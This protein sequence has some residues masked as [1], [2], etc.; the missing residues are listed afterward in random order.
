MQFAMLKSDTCF[1]NILSV[2][3]GLHVLINF[4]QFLSYDQNLSALELYLWELFQGLGFITP[5]MI[6]IPA[7]YKGMLSM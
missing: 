3:C 2:S 6:C 5:K 1:G 7:N 4:W